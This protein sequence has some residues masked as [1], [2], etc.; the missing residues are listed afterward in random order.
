MRLLSEVV[1]GFRV[2]VSAIR[3]NKMRSSLA[4]LGIVIGIVTVTLMGTAIEGL[5][6]AFIKSIS[7]I[8]SDV[9]YVQKFSWF[10]HEEWWKMRNRRDILLRD[11]RSLAK[12]VTMASAVSPWVEDFGAVEYENRSAS[13]VQIVGCGAETATVSS[14]TVTSGRFL[15]AE[16]VDG[17]RPVCVLGA[18]LAANFFPH[19]QA[20]GRK[21]RIKGN[22]YEVVGVLG[23]I[24]SFLGIVNF[25]NRVMIPITRY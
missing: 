14:L 4:T 20:V 5:N 19:E 24:G 17:G 8:G 18:D 12:L 21:I 3:A 1:E 11:S 6:R 23:K 10:G 16:E 22:A 7:A 15:S 9:L 2:S 13:S 25:D